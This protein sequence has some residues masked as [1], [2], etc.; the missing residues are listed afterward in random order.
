M[1]EAINSL[2]DRMMPGYRHRAVVVV[3]WAM[4]LTGIS[5][6]RDWAVRS[7][8]GVDSVRERRP[9]KGAYGR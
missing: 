3:V 6:R 1:P 7:N 9:I 5:V 2:I 4:V 8:I